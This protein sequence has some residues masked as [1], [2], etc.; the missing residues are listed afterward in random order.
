MK[1]AIEI[2]PRLLNKFKAVLFSH[3]WTSYSPPGMREEQAMEGVVSGAGWRE[4][5]PSGAGANQRTGGERK[6]TV[7]VRNDMVTAVAVR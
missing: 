7:A 1:T 6:S 3:Q 2:I 4:A 5:S